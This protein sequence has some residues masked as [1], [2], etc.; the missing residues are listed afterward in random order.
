MQIKFPALL[1][2][3]M[4]DSFNKKQSPE[5][6]A[7]MINTPKNKFSGSGTLYLVWGIVVLIFSFSQF[8]LGNL[9]GYKNAHYVWFFTW[10]VYIYQAIFLF[11]KKKNLKVK[12]YTDEIIGYVWICF[13]ICFFIML[14]ILLYSKSFN[15]IYLSILVLY[16]TPT[17]LSGTIFKT[18][19]LLIGNICCWALASISL[20]I[21][22]KCQLLLISLAVLLVWIIPCVYFKNKYLNNSKLLLK[23]NQC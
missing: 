5:V 23:F 15:L 9:S 1:I 14:F 17:F 12:T 22:L 10:A 19:P 16:A 7:G 2:F 13:I 18:K 11:R 4:E 6:I 20:F 8:V 21:S 3:F